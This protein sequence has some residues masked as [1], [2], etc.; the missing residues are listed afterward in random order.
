MNSKGHDKSEVPTPAVAPAKKHTGKFITNGCTADS[1]ILF[2]PYNASYQSGLT[3]VKIDTLI[4][5]TNDVE[6]NGAQMPL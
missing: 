5:L 1:P 3:P 4:D 2:Q 6:N